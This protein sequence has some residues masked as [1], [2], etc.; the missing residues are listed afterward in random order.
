[1]DVTCTG[2][3]TMCPYRG[4]L[5]RLPTERAPSARTPDHVPDVKGISAPMR[6]RALLQLHGATQ[7]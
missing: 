5:P 3:V 6:P 1:M 4:S 2:G 7:Y